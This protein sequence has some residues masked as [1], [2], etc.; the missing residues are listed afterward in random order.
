MD[1][2]SGDESWPASDP[3]ALIFATGDNRVKGSVATRFEGVPTD[4]AYVFQYDGL[5]MHVSLFARDVAVR[6]GTSVAGR[7]R[8]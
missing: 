8:H 7:D 5:F 1:R 6:S 3:H 4:V 2:H